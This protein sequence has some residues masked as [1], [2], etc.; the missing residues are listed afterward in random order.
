MTSTPRTTDDITRGFT[1]DGAPVTGRVVRLGPGTINPI[2]NRHDYPP[3][4]AT[5]LGEALALAA[6]VG[7]SMKFDG[8]LMIQAEGDG[9]A[10][11]L[12]VDYSS[13]GALRGMVRIDDA[14]RVASMP[15]RVPPHD[16]LG[17]GALRFSIDQ[18]PDFELYQGIAELNGEN[19]AS[20]AEAWF[21]QSEQVPSR[22]KLSVGEVLRPDSFSEW[23]AG[24]ML[25]QRV[26]GDDARGDTEEDWSRAGILFETLRDDELLDPD[27]A[28]EQLAVRLFHEEG[29]RAAPALGLV[30]ACSCSREKLGAIL[31]RYPAEELKDLAG[32]ENTISATCQFCARTYRFSPDDLIAV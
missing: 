19:L 25:I 10:G 6:L 18:G 14:A 23:R 21:E 4:I 32:E 27:L 13:A 22:I 7:A 16:L 28:A 24:G 30:D 20:C 15:R 9:P 11:L 12:A 2:L 3:A 8:R 26:A 17:N 1:L 29:V 31:K 5:L